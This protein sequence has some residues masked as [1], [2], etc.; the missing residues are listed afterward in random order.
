MKKKDLIKCVVAAILCLAATSCSKDSGSTPEQEFIDNFNALVMGGKTIDTHQDWNTVGNVSVKISVDFGNEKDYT[1]YILQTPPLLGDKGVYLGMAKIKSGASKT[2]SIPKPAN[3]GLLYAACFESGGHADCKPFPVTAENAEVVFNSKSPSQTTT[4]DGTTGNRWSVVAPE[5]PDLSPYTE[6]S[7]V[8][9]T[10]Q[11]I[12][13]SDETPVHFKVSKNFTGS[14]PSLA[15]YKQKSVYVTSTWQLNEDQ[16]VDKG[17]VIVVGNGGKLVI[18]RSRSL[19]TGP[20]TD[21]APGLIIVL[22]GGE[23]SGEGN[24]SITTADG[25]YCY[26]AGNIITKNI[27]LNG[28]SLYN[29]GTINEGS[30]ISGIANGTKPNL[31]VNTGDISLTEITGDNIAIENGG[32]IKILKEIVLSSSSKMDDGSQLDCTKLTLNGNQ[33]GSATLY[34]GNAAY[35]N[36]LNSISIDHFGVWGPAGDGFKANAILKV[37]GCSQC[38]SAGGKPGCYMLDHVE[39]IL[40]S[41]FPTIYDNGAINVWD[42]EIKGIGI[43]T[44][45]PSFSGY[46]NLCMFYQWLNGYDG[47]IINPSNYIWAQ[48]GNKYNFT[49]DSSISPCADG[50]ESSRQTCSYSIAPSYSDGD[51]RFLTA[52][53]GDLPNQGSIFYAFEILESNTKDF[54]YNDIV[55]RVNVP[56][57]NGSG[58]Y[59]S[60]IQVMCVGNT[61]KTSVYYNGQQLGEEVH[62]A[63]GIDPKKTANASTVD[64][65]FRKLGDITFNSSDFKL[66]QLNFTVKTEDDKGDIKEMKQPA[67]LGEAPL[68]LIINGDASFKWYWPKEGMNIGVAYPQFST[69]GANVQSAIDW[70]DSANATSSKVVSY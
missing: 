38:N 53:T 49:W 50:I 62:S 63:M 25:A 51:N 47:R 36:C 29:E 65:A 68:Y 12:E 52:K 8:E 27:Q 22:E 21:E 10:D 7:L 43:G 24:I 26:N 56:T 48:S 28:G 69:W 57:D 1:V 15:E 31:F 44:L 64:M 20:Q 18:P 6:G 13:F 55:L 23:I 2:I 40:P 54:D 34:M 37:N 66:D 11:D 17:N 46:N 60:A 39:L 42:S 16:R 9:A 58:T 19:S 70:Y 32:Y 61:H 4:Y 30:T 41:S 59:T 45:Q 33:D 14:I 5:L 35:L 67:T 3:C